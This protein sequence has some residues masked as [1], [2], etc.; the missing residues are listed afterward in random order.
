MILATLDSDKVKL[1]NVNHS[2]LNI[3]NLHKRSMITPEAWTP[4]IINRNF[5]EQ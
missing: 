4:V 2:E 3:W 1:W 5:T